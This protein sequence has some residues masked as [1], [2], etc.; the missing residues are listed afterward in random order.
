[1]SYLIEKLLKNII[2]QVITLFSQ[3]EGDVL[4]RALD[5]A[6]L[7]MVA[8]YMPLFTQ[9]SFLF[10]II[11]VVGYIGMNYIARNNSSAATPSELFWRCTIAIVVSCNSWQIVTTVFKIFNKI[12]SE[13]ATF[14]ANLSYDASE[15]GIVSLV[16][17][18]IGLIGL[19]ITYIQASIRSAKIAILCL[20]GPIFAIGYIRDDKAMFVGWIR[21][22]IA[23]G[24]GQIVQI[25]LFNLSMQVFA[26]LDGFAITR[27]LTFL[28]VVMMMIT[29]PK[30][31]KGIIETTGTGK[32]LAG[33][34][35]QATMMVMARKVLTKGV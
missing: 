12:A 8:N 35:K 28:G 5:L 6:E 18:I 27:T 32:A 23:L 26:S 20:L 4:A 13:I 33:G 25:L 15:L 34:G 9:L 29:S 7:P 21:E 22:V 11:Y 2:D 19:L 3:L 31:L 1:M 14:D 30:W 17:I 10:L 24:F 16:I